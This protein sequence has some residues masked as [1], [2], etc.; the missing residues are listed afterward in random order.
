MTMV[1]TPLWDM[2]DMNSKIIFLM[3]LLSG[4]GFAVSDINITG[5]SFID[6]D[7]NVTGRI[8]G[9]IAATGISGN[10]S[11]VENLSVGSGTLFVDALNGRVGIGAMPLTTLYVSGNINVTSGN[12]ICIDNLYCLTTAN[13]SAGGWTDEGALVRLTMSTD[14]INATTLFINNTLRMVGINTVPNATLHVSGT[15]LQDPNKT[16]S[17]VGSVTDGPKMENARSLYVQG[18]YAY[19]TSQTNDSLTIIDI[20]DPTNPVI[21]A[22]HTNSTGL[23]QAADIFVK[24]KYAYI[25]GLARDALSII[26]VS[27]VTNPKK[28]SEV[29]DTSRLD[30]IAYPYI[31]GKYA[32]VASYLNDSL[33]VIDISDPTSASIVGYVTNSTVLEGAV[34][35]KVQG[36]YAYVASQNNDSLTIIDV[37]NPAEPFIVGSVT[38]LRLEVAWDVYVSGGY[39][40]VPGRYNDSL[41]I[42]NVTDVSKPSIIGFIVDSSNIEGAIGVTVQGNYAYLAS[43]VSGSLSVIDI[44]DKTTPRIIS[45]LSETGLTG[46][47]R[48]F[49]SGKYAYVVANT[50]DS[51]TVV[52]I[53]GI[54]SSTASIG[55]LESSTVHV[56]ENAKIGNDVYVT[57]GLMTDGL[58]ID[59]PVSFMNDTLITTSAGRVGINNTN[60]T[61][62]LD[63]GGNIMVNGSGGNDPY[64]YFGK[65]GYIYDNGTDLVFGHG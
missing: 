9:K 32:Y 31:S 59:G 64:I 51:L 33:S 11:I 24:G 23:E 48:V 63:V 29:R 54:D 62:V 57:G 49:V 14:D 12:D 34:A 58:K 50:N 35:V 26:D 25:A 15:L 7:L 6:V 61:Q 20:S 46:A 1:H 39:A 3:V 56:I 16:M 42:I 30:G 18:K 13:I 8:S 10:L 36:S 47:T 19:V 5:S 60:P 22:Y 28:V 55:A 27:N 17:V 40:Y 41:C 38:D 44:S 43:I 21:V 2:I 53:V 65:G 37:S 4:V 45:T 52:D